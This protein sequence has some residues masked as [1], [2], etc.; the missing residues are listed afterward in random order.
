MIAPR[1]GSQS[2][3]RRDTGIAIIISEEIAPEISPK[4]T[5][6]FLIS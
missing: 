5:T 1:S 4:V 2:Y 6:I 3:L